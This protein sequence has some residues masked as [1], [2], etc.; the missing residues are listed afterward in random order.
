MIIRT[1]IFGAMILIVL[2]MMIPTVHAIDQATWQ[3]MT[4]YARLYTIGYKDGISKQP[5]NP[6]PTWSKMQQ[7]FYQD[8]Y[9]D[10]AKDLLKDMVRSDLGMPP[11][12]EMNK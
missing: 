1:L 3:N 6:D 9:D 7:Q 2:T 5:S 8:G 4:T 12:Y 10:A 11:L